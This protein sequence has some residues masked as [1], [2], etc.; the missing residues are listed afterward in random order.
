MEDSAAHRDI[1][2]TRNPITAV[3]RGVPAQVLVLSACREGG[4][5]VHAS[6][7]TSFAFTRDLLLGVHL[8]GEAYKVRDRTLG[9]SLAAVLGCRRA[10]RD[11]RYCTFP[12]T[13]EACPSAA[14]S[15]L[16]LINDIHH[17]EG[18]EEPSAP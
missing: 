14:R 18:E 1:V 16:A 17:L 9:C 11:K 3:A 6:D 7:R 12:Q 10:S 13:L 2:F 8:Y 4:F 5:F 15:R